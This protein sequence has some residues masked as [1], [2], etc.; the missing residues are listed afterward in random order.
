MIVY[1]DGHHLSHR[2]M[3]NDDMCDKWIELEVL[4]DSLR[5]KCEYTPMWLWWLWQSSPG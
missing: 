4:K 5:N 2:T 1:R 3:E